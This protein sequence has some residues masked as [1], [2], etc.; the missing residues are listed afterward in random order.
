MRNRRQ[1]HSQYVR[2]ITNAELLFGKQ[3]YDFGSGLVAKHLKDLRDAADFQ[4]EF[5]VV[6]ITWPV[7]GR[8]VFAYVM[9]CVCLVHFLDLN[10]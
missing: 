1:R 10:T 5:R 6:G 8:E 9:V 3:I 2:E 4:Y 7:V